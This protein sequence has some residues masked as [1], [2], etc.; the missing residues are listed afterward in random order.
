MHATNTGVVMAPSVFDGT[1][2]TVA[3]IVLLLEFLMLRSALL[4]AQ[5]RPAPQNAG[6][7]IGGIRDVRSTLHVQILPLRDIRPTDLVR[8]TT[9]HSGSSA[10]SDCR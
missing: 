3:M 2:S 1:A 7:A 4:R 6:T 10:D 5:I 8:Q 9:T